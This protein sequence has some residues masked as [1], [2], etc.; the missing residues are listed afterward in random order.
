MAEARLFNRF[1]SHQLVKVTDEHGT[2]LTNIRDFSANGVSFFI[3]QQLTRHTPITL[4]LNMHMPK[5]PR[6]IAVDARVAWTGRV[7]RRGPY[8]AGAEFTRI[9][10]ADRAYLQQLIDHV[11]TEYR[12]AKHAEER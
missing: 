7:G 11:R 12:R 9:A 4:L 8:M 1:R 10:A 5:A 2:E 6:Q 3:G